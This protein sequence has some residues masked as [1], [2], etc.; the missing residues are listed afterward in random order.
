LNSDWVNSQFADEFGDRPNP[1]SMGGREVSRLIDAL[2]RAG[3]GR[4]RYANDL[5][6]LEEE[7]ALFHAST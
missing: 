7:F 4:S 6:G 1:K 2:L 3:Y 5:Q